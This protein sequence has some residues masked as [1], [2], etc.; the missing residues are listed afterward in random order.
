MV[1]VMSMA[2]WSLALT[3]PAAIVGAGLFY[4]AAEL[5]GIAI[6]LSDIADEIRGEKKR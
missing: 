2:E 3:L 6:A 4:I 5:G 1:L